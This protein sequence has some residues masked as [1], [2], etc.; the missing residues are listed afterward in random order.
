MK[1]FYNCIYNVHTK[2][3]ENG[4]K[5]SCDATISSNKIW[6]DVTSAKAISSVLSLVRVPGEKDAP[7]CSQPCTVLTAAAVKPFPYKGEAQ[8][9][10]ER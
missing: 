3:G 7:S 1:E 9:G 8:A 6:D 10:P 4:I 2:Y 5:K